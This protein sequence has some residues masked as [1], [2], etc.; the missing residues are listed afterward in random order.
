VREAALDLVRRQTEACDHL[1]GFLLM[2]SMAGGTGAGLGAYVAS[3]LRDD[4]PSAALL[5]HCIW[6]YESGEVI[7]QCYNTLLTLAALLDVSD[8]WGRRTTLR[9]TPDEWQHTRHIMPF[10]SRNEGFGMR[11]DA[12]AGNGSGRH[13]SPRHRMPFNSRNEGSQCVSMTW[14]E[15]IGCPWRRP[16]HRA[17]RAPAR[18]VPGAAKGTACQILLAI[19]SIA[20]EPSFRE[21]N[22]IR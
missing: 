10:I 22:G 14:R 4:Y 20:F 5:N 9:G 17:E 18:R 11:V 15:V 13:R 6:P 21:L 12:V 19:L 1:G 7:V 2:Q 16:H 8:G 3:A